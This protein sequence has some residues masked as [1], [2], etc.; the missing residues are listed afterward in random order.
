MA[1]KRT[2]LRFFT[3]FYNKKQKNFT[4]AGIFIY[5]AV[6]EQ[7]KQITA[8]QVYPSVKSAA[9]DKKYRSTYTCLQRLLVS[10]RHKSNDKFK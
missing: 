9:I 6:F 8:P 4:R 2:K 3:N 10:S 5:K 7:R 1:C